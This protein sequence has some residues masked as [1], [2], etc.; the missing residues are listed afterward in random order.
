MF[1]K[2]KTVRR[3]LSKVQLFLRRHKWV[4]P[5]VVIP[6][7]VIPI[8]VQTYGTL[9]GP[10]VVVYKYSWE[11]QSLLDREAQRQAID[12]VIRRGGI[13]PPPSQ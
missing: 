2:F 1:Q 3:T 5:A 4:L 7:V 9:W 8:A 6:I 13:A 10:H 11:L 12:G